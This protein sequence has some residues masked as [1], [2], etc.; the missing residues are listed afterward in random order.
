MQEYILQSRAARITSYAGGVALSVACLVLIPWMISTAWSV[1]Q[2]FEVSPQSHLAFMEYMA[3]LAQRAKEDPDA[4]KSLREQEEL[5]RNVAASRRTL[6]LVLCLMCLQG[7][8]GLAGGIMMIGAPIAAAR[9]TRRRAQAWQTS[10]HGFPMYRNNLASEMLP[11]VF[12]FLFGGLLLVIL[13][14]Q[15][16]WGL[17]FRLSYAVLVGLVVAILLVAGAHLPWR[18]HCRDWRIRLAEIPV[19]PGELVQFEIFR[20]SGKPLDKDLRMELVGWQPKWNTK[21][22]CYKSCWSFLFHTIPGEVHLDA[23]PGPDSASIRGTLRFEGTNLVAVPPDGVKYPR[24][25]IPFLRVRKGWWR[26]CL[27]DLPAPALYVLPRER[28]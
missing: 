28:A 9:R 13:V 27:F 14:L 3:Q 26:R 1:G 22:D 18:L 10:R 11:L 25:L 7:V 20:E 16:I 21:R 8:F 6:S 12:L 17:E 19:R 15:T 5:E 4:A 23:A 2:F 24:R